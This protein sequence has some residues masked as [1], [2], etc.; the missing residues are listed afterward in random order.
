MIAS[1]SCGFKPL[2]L[3]SSSFFHSLKRRGRKSDRHYCSKR[4]WDQTFPGGAVYLLRITY[5]SYHGLWVGYIKSIL[6]ELK[7]ASSGALSRKFCMLTS[8]LTVNSRA[9]SRAKRAQRSTI[10][11]KIWLS[12]HPRNFG[13]DKIVRTEYVRTFTPSCKPDGNFAFQVPARFGGKSHSHPYF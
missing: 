13:S 11:K 2:D 3:S 1:L 6:N 4:V 12:M 5:H 7:V 10:G 9:L 8:K